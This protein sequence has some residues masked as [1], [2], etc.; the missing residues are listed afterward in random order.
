MQVERAKYGA[1]ETNPKIHDDEVQGIVS[2]T[3]LGRG[4]Y[5]S[6]R[7]RLLMDVKEGVVDISYFH[8]RD[9]QGRL[10]RV[11]GLPFAP[12]DLTPRNYKSRLYIALKYHNLFVADIFDTISIL[13]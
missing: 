4:R 12:G 2:F 1:R 11:T 3:D 13:S 8:V 5:K 9:K 7:L 10:L 6:D